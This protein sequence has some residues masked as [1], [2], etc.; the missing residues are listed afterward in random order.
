MKN[1]LVKNVHP[2]L[3]P[4]KHKIVDNGLLII[5][6]VNILLI[7]H[8]CNLGV[9]ILLP[10]LV[11][12]D[13]FMK[14]SYGFGYRVIGEHHFCSLYFGYNHLTIHKLWIPFEHPDEFWVDSLR[15]VEEKPCPIE[16]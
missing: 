10:S 14:A 11:I 3:C 1:I 8:P 16:K 2:Y 13:T 15:L 9:I 7:E 4:F 6:L 5:N 12:S